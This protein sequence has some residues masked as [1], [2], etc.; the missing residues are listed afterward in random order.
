MVKVAVMMPAYNAAQ[1]IE[2]ALASLLRQRDAAH[3][4]IIV[5]NDGSTDGT[6][7]IVRRLAA[8]APEIRLIETANQR[9]SRARNVALDALADDTDLVTTLDA[10]DLSPAGRFARD[11]AHFARD[12]QLELHY[13]FMTAFRGAVEDFAPAPGTRSA[14]SRGVHLG[15]MLARLSLVR[16]VGPFDVSCVQAEDLDY[17]MRMTELGPRMLLGDD[18]CYYYRRHPSNISGDGRE[19]RKWLA[20]AMLKS[21]H[22]RRKNPALVTPKGLF[23]AGSFTDDDKAWWFEDSPPAS[24][25]A[26]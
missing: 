11:I 20:H 5:V 15:L 21:A 25:R 17:I 8:Q 16:R 26:S 2:D 7:D 14:T 22:R 13:G 12:P 1:Y 10:D 3:F 24:N 9:I 19:G 18:V 6:G 4:D 23:D